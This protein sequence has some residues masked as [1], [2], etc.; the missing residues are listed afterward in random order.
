M[1]HLTYSNSSTPRTPGDINDFYRGAEKSD[2][3]TI[4]QSPAEE[5]R[6]I[7]I[8]MA[9]DITAWREAR[10]NKELRQ[11]PLEPMTS[12]KNDGNNLL[13]RLIG[14][15]FVSSPTDTHSRSQLVRRVIGQEKA[16][17][18]NIFA[19]DDK[20]KIRH[21]FFMLDEHTW[22]WHRE[23]P[24]S[25]MVTRYEVKEDMVLKSQ[26]EH[27]YHQVGSPEEEARLLEAIKIYHERCREYYS[28]PL[29]AAA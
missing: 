16:T 1:S 27:S 18:G 7:A 14:K 10:I 25:S 11:K 17:V 4:E 12:G 8:R 23:T 9:K 5:R 28:Q 24:E 29:T 13:S 22:V 6:R 15:L 3:R 26:G 19:A 2:L 20:D 21:E